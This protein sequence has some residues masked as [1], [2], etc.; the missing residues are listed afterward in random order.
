MVTA[1]AF[2]VARGPTERLA[3][4]IAFYIAF[5]PEWLMGVLS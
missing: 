1:A 4:W 2:I 3:D 5:P